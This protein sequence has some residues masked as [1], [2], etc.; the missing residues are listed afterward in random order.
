MKAYPI[1]KVPKSM[2]IIIN[3]SSFVIGTIFTFRFVSNIL[4]YMNFDIGVVSNE[5]LKMVR[6]SG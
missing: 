6:S 1:P 3:T 4:F 5:K 2:P